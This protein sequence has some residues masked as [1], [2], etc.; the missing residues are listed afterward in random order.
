M[1]VKDLETI[2]EKLRRVYELSERGVEGERETAKRTLERLLQK[3]NLSLEELVSEEKEPVLFQYAN[4][5]EETLLIQILGMVMGVRQVPTWKPPR[6]RN[7]RIALLT[8]AQAIDAQT[9]YDHYRKALK[10]HLDEAIEAFI[11]ANHLFPKAEGN[12]T[13]ER[14]PLTPAE[15]AR[16][17]R[18]L[19]MMNGLEATP[20]PR[21][22]LEGQP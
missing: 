14:K 21:R 4:K 6:T 15:I 17:Q 1:K 7:K 19:Q 10:R 8:K 2:K 13:Q 5:W 20:L 9:Y 12:D 3:H 18:I 22:M 11:G 16:L